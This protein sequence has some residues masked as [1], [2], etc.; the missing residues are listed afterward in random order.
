MKTKMSSE[1]EHEEGLEKKEKK[2]K[3]EKTRDQQLTTVARAVAPVVAGGFNELVLAATHWAVQN[4]APHVGFKPKKKKIDKRQLTAWRK[5]LDKAMERIII[6]YAPS[7]NNPIIAYL[8]TFI[9]FFFMYDYEKLPPKKK[10]KGE[11]ASDSTDGP[12]EGTPQ[13]DNGDSGTR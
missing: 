4:G 10:K 9:S 7:L 1:N 11:P 3:K 2:A 13:P 8:V 5:K 6:A 12:G